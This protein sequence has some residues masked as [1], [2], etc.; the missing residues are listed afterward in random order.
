MNV[1]EFEV[2]NQFL[3]RKTKSK[4]VNKSHNYLKFCFSFSSEWDET[5]KQYLICKD[6]KGAYQFDV[7]EGVV[8]VP[9]PLIAEKQL[10]ITLYGVY[11]DKSRIT[12]NEV[13]L[14]L[15]HSGYTRDISS[16]DYDEDVEDVIA[17]FDLDLEHIKEA[18]SHMVDE[19]VLEDGVL[20]GYSEGELVFSYTLDDSHTHTIETI[21]DFSE[22]T[23]VEIRCA[24]RYL[25]NAIRSSSSNGG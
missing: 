11:Q 8:I 6:S 13:T 25:K 3:S 24:F 12:T 2:D 4:I 21:P 16:F 17:R 10:L 22:N 9:F 14:K 15:V 18:I 1:V 20:K 23:A 7:N 5:V 19:V